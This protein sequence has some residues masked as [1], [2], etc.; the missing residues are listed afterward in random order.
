MIRAIDVFDAIEYS[1]FYV[2]LINKNKKAVKIAKKYKKA[3]IGTSDAHYL[4]QMNNTYS[5]IN[6][7][8]DILSV[9]NA[10]KKK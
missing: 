7:K 3:L 10:V 8:K 2:K 9:I 1:C 6:S 4:W 5:L